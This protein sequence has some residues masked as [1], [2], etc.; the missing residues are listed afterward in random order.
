MICAT[1]QRKV[2][3]CPGPVEISWTEYLLQLKAKLHVSYMLVHPETLDFD[4]VTPFEEEKLLSIEVII[5]RYYFSAPNIPTVFHPVGI[6][7]ACF[8]DTWVTCI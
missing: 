6:S 4:L 2:K 3:S 1:I 5:W 7:I 8:Q